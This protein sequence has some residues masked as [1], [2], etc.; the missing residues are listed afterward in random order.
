V[1]GHCGGVG[2]S[3]TQ[4]ETSKAQPSEKNIDDGT[5]GQARILSGNLLGRAALRELRE[6]LGSN[7]CEN[8]ATGKEGEVDYRRHKLSPRKKNWRYACRLLVTNSLK[9]GAMWPVD[10]LLGNDREISNYT[11]A[12]TR[13]RPVESN[14]VFCAILVEML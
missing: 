6:Q 12:V 5:S 2:P 14:R 8:R 9:E 1:T 4:E 13:Q 10:P 11:T 7:H 3:E